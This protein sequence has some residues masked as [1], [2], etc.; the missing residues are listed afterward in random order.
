MY[1]ITK[2]PEGIAVYQILKLSWEVKTPE[3]R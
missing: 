1:R 2:R 3:S